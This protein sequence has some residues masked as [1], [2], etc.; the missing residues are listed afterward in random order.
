VYGIVKKYHGSIRIESEV[1]RGTMFEISLP[2]ATDEEKTAPEPVAVPV[3]AMN[4]LI[5]DSDALSR[6]IFAKCLRNDG[7][8]V[9]AAASTGEAD[10]K[11]KSRHFDIIVVDVATPGCNGNGVEFARA[12]KMKT[13][14]TGTILMSGSSRD[15]KADA[16]RIEGVDV[17]LPKPATISELRGAI[18]DAAQKIRDYKTATGQAESNPTS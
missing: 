16:Q 2:A 5:Y 4:V 3:E 9:V 12:V 14:G 13:P 1:G 15:L 10:K 7:H 8:K 6:E 17:I 18:S 11:V